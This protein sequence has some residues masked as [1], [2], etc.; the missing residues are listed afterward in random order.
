VTCSPARHQRPLVI[1]LATVLVGV[2]LGLFQPGTARAV[3]G[4]ETPSPTPPW[5]A[6][7]TIDGNRTCSGALIAE[8]WVLTAA[9]CVRRNNTGATRPA[10]QFSVALGQTSRGRG[11]FVIRVDRAPLSQPIQILGNGLGTINDI[12]LLHLA[13]PAPS[14]LSPLPLRFA[15]GAVPTGSQVQF[16]GWG[17]NGS[18]IGQTLRT[19]HPG[20]WTFRDTCAT[21]GQVCYDRAPGGTSYPHAGDSGSPV[22]AMARGGLVQVG[23]HSGPGGTA[24]PKHGASVLG[25]LEWIRT[26]TSLPEFRPNTIVRDRT[27]GASWWI[28]PD[29]FRRWIPNGATYNC[30]VRSG[31]PVRQV[32]RYEALSAPEDYTARATCSDAPTPPSYTTPAISLT[33]GARAPSG[34]WYSVSLSGFPRG[35]RVALTCRD[36]VDPGGFFRRTVVVGRDGQATTARL[37]YSGDGPDHWVTGAGIESNRA[38]WGAATMPPP[39]P[40][41]PPPPATFTGSPAAPN[42]VGIFVS[43]LPNTPCPA[44]SI[45]VDAFLDGRQVTTASV[46]ASTGMWSMQVSTQDA[47]PGTHSLEVRCDPNNGQPPTLTYAS[48]T[49]F[50]TAAL[51]TGFDL[52]RASSTSYTGTIT[53]GSP[54]P[55]QTD[56]VHVA[57]LADQPPG[58]PDW[59]GGKSAPVSSTGAWV[60]V[61]VPI[62]TMAPG[63]V[64][65]A[66]AVCLDGEQSRYLYQ[67]PNVV[68]VP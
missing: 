35:A 51:T 6:R 22:V 59:H 57:L 68:P 34:Y 27:T 20:D 7:I 41:P 4:G 42:P 58:L 62:P 31:T 15:S 14:W 33:Q 53:P 55:V 52:T 37:C 25:Y 19:T 17:Y 2:M 65:S 11:G 40:P 9:H 21:N 26:R 28:A 3:V 5:N 61:S 46:N 36:S 56:S 48:T 64:Y 60:A 29:G 10:S 47:A 45:R 67:T 54:C 13:A 24:T 30:L 66:Q 18:A 50:L 8:R 12:A 16:V 49:Y 63:T 1:A 44:G 43:L 23:I 32:T 39:P 38:T